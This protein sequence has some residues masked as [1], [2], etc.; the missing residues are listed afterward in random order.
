[1]EPEV[2][3][4][5]EIDVA[6]VESTDFNFEDLEEDKTDKETSESTPEEDEDSLDK[7]DEE[8]TFE[9]ASTEIVPRRVV[10]REKI[11]QSDE[12]DN[13]SLSDLKGSEVSPDYNIQYV[14]EETIPQGGVVRTISGKV[15][16]RFKRIFRSSKEEKAPEPEE[17]STEEETLSVQ[18]L[19]LEP[20][21]I[22]DSKDNVDYDDTEARRALPVVRVT[23]DVGDMEPEVVISD[24]IDVA[25]VESTDFNFED[26][27]E[28][29]TDKETSESTPEEDKDSLDKHDE[30][31]TFETASTEIVPR[32]VVYRE[33]IV[34]SDEHD[35]N[36][37][38]DLK[39]SEV[40]P[41][42]NIQYVE[43][44]TIPQGGFVRTISGKVAGRFKRIFRSS[45][46][47]KAPEPEEIS[48]EK[49]TL[50]VQPL[51]LEPV[52]IAD[53]KDNVDDDDTEAR[54]ALPVVRVTVDVGDMEPE[55]VISD[56]I[57]VAVVESTDFYFEDLEEDEPD[58][59]T[60][61]SIPEEDKDSLDNYDEEATF[62]TA[63]TGIVPRRVVYREKIVQSDEHDNN[64]LSDLKGSE[65]SPDYNIQYV[66]EETIPQG[67]VVRT[68]SG[69]VTGRFKRIFRSSKEEKAPEPEEI[70]TEEET[71]SVQPLSLEPVSITDS[72]DNV[73]YDDTEA[74]RALPVVRVTV[75]VGDMEPEVVIS[76][77]I[78]VAVVESTDFN[79]ED[80]EEDE[81]DKET[82]ESTPEEDEDSLDKHDE[83]ATF[84]TA[85]TEIV[86][87]RVVYREKIVQP[88]EHDN[89]SLSDLKCSEVS[90]DY[91][92]QYVE[93][94][95]IPQGGFVRTISGKVTG[96]FNRIF[97]RSKEEKAP[98]PEEILTEEETLSVQPLSL[99]PVSIADS[100][101]NVDYDDTEARRALPVVRVTVDVGDMEPE[102]VISDEID[103]ALVESTDF[104]FED[105][106]EDETDKETS[107]STFEEDEDSLDKHDEEAFF[108]TASTEIV[109]KRVVYRE[110]IVQSD[111]HDN[112]SLSDLKGSEVSPDYNIQYVEE[113]TI[114][115][116][117]FVRTISGK[118]TG[119]FKRIFRSS[120]EGKAPEPKEILTEE[121]TLSVQPLRLEPVSIADSKDNVDDDDTEA[122][123][124]LPVVRVTVDVGDMEPEVVISDEI[125]V[126]VVESTDFNF[127]DLEEDET[128]KETSESTP[129]EDED[130]LDKHDEEAFFETASTEIVP[131]RVV[132]REKIVQSDEYDNNSLSDLKGSEVS[133]DY[134]IQYVEEETIPQGGVV[135]TISGKVTG[136]FKR[137]F[138][139]SKEE[140][141]PEPEEISTEEETLS[142]QPLSLEPVSI[143]DSKDN[144]DDDDTE[145]R[146]ALP[147]VRVTIDVGDMEPEVVISDEIDVAVVESTDFNFE[148]LEEDE[149]DKETSDSTPEDDKDSLDKHDEEA[150]FETASTEIVPR[151]V[152]YREKIV[153]SDEHDNNSLSD[154]KGSEVS[155]DYNIQYVE[156]E[157]IPQGGVVRTISGKVTGRFK[158]IFRS[159]KE[160]KEPEPEEISTEE[161]TL[162]VQPLSLEPVSIADSKDNVDDDDTE[163]RRALP[164]VRVTID[165]GDME[166]EVVISDEIDVAVV[167]STDFNFEDLE[168]DETD[169]ETSESTPEEDEDSLNNEQVIV[170]SFPTD[171]GLEAKSSD[172]PL[173]FDLESSEIKEDPIVLF[174]APDSFDLKTWS[175]DVDVKEEPIIESLVPIEFLGK[176]QLCEM[177]LFGEP[178]CVYKIPVDDVRTDCHHAFKND[179]SCISGLAAEVPF[180][181]NK[182]ADE[183]NLEHRIKA[184]VVPDLQEKKSRLVIEQFVET[185]LNRIIRNVFVYE[186]SR[187]HQKDQ[188]P[189]D[190][191]Q[192]EVLI[193]TMEGQEPKDM[194]VEEYLAMMREDQETKD[195]TVEDYLAMMKKVREPNDITVEEYLSMMKEDQEP[196]DMTVE[197]YLSMMKEDREPNDMTVEEYLSM[198]KEDQG[199]KDMTVEEYLSVMREDQETKDQTVEEYLAM[200]KKVREPNDITVEEY[201]SMMKE[202]RE[203]NDIT[204]EEYLSMMKEDQEPKDM[205][206]EEYLLRMKE[207]QEPKDM[208]VEKYLSMI[209]E[210]QEP[211]DITVEEYLLMMKEDQEP[212]DMTVEEYLSMMKED[213]GPK[214]MTVEE[215]LS[216]IKEDE[217]QKD[218]TVEKYLSMIKEDEA[219]KDITVEEYL[220]M[221]KKYQEPKDMTVEE[222]LSMMKE[223]QEPKDMTVEKYLSMIKEDE[224]QK[225]ITVEEYLSMMKK[226]QEPKDITV[227]EY[228]SMMKEDQEPKDMT[229]EKYLSMM[230]EDQ[231]TKDQTVEEYLAMMKKVREPKDV[232]VEEYL[233]ILNKDKEPK[234]K[235]VEEYL[236]MMKEDEELK[237]MPIEE[238]L[239]MIEMRRKIKDNEILSQMKTRKL[240]LFTSTFEFT[241]KTPSRLNPFKFFSVCYIHDRPVDPECKSMQKGEKSQIDIEILGRYVAVEERTVTLEFETMAS[242]QAFV[243]TDKD[244]LVNGIHVQ[245]AG[246][247]YVL[248]VT[249]LES[250]IS[251]YDDTVPEF[252]QIALE[253]LV[254]EI[255]IFEE[256]FPS[257]KDTAIE[258][259]VHRS[260][261][262]EDMIQDNWMNDKK[263]LDLD[264]CLAD[265]VYFSAKT[266]PTRHCTEVLLFKRSLR[267][268]PW[269]L[270]LRF[271]ESPAAV[272]SFEPK[273]ENRMDA[274]EI[275]IKSN[276]ETAMLSLPCQLRLVQ[277]KTVSVIYQT[278]TSKYSLESSRSMPAFYQEVDIKVKRQVHGRVSERARAE[279]DRKVSRP[280]KDK[281]Q[282]EAKALK[283]P[284]VFKKTDGGDD[285]IQ[286][287]KDFGV[288][289]RRKLLEEKWQ[290]SLRENDSLKSQEFRGIE[291]K[292]S[293]IIDVGD[294]TKSSAIEKLPLGVEE[295]K[296]NAK[297]SA[298]LF[299]KGRQV[300]G[301][302]ETEDSVLDTTNDSEVGKG[303]KTPFRR[304]RSRQ[305]RDVPRVI[306]KRQKL[307]A[308][309]FG[310]Q[311]DSEISGTETFTE[312]EDGSAFAITAS[313]SVS[314]RASFRSHLRENGF[315]VED[316]S[317]F[318][319]AGSPLPHSKES[320]LSEAETIPES[321]DGSLF[322]LTGSV[323][324]QVSESELSSSDTVVESEDG[325]TFAV[326]GNRSRLISEG[327]S[328]AIIGSPIPI[329]LEDDTLFARD[330]HQN[331][332]AYAITGRK[333]R[334]SESTDEDLAA[335]E[336]RSREL[337]KKTG[338]KN[339]SK[340]AT[341]V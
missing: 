260:K 112:N 47:E 154:L 303:K 34:Q 185:V 220:S 121:E 315:A 136:R 79:F 273:A 293:E 59:E 307:S 332:S 145:A 82:S 184:N 21:S 25:V 239:K 235:T 298:Y 7:H 335:R 106:E 122:R 149:T 147:V 164:V 271:F 86:P 304:S 77:E 322:A 177:R 167:E 243:S 285:R 182:D 49:E 53:S 319:V 119:R 17:I 311:E 37:L 208:T 62:E 216:M 295:L 66:E 301:E 186:I 234:D 45:K 78:D 124:A 207:D 8:A 84:E 110:K 55:V 257:Y 284:P 74:R 288:M 274:S 202:D 201:L 141:E 68:I 227:E 305:S 176:S 195:Q 42:Y 150:S 196:K 61:D 340:L 252:D 133:P 163:A 279:G 261:Q 262:E 204:V 15:T 108:E 56:E 325:C 240:E 28:D 192:V 289:S 226:Y 30:E 130:S 39:G 215:Y 18:P 102:V 85:S 248:P 222:Y 24:E 11:V 29:E 156:E 337:V 83:E 341:F 217:E 329:V 299:S 54:R 219:Q 137:I 203:P 40:S 314:P 233:A 292:T 89:D 171:H 291:I 138:R 32:R 127:E 256:N 134:N 52:S 3:I 232:T 93:E 241:R 16:G 94:E 107:E 115:Q 245:E 225:D 44:E 140:K 64:S 296:G 323:K 237:D 160:E 172:T 230:R 169:K 131:R 168:E 206:V 129:E 157:T 276:Y 251:K 36:S 270:T 328:F 317:T 67:G 65:V 116:G 189:K 165:V 231:D 333:S 278:V 81:T 2:V 255:V 221:M 286:I 158:R 223:D 170:Y 70:S 174:T 97:R 22:T 180:K 1:M 146:R 155:P 324:G 190:A 310:H 152:V 209:K 14:E 35:N 46:E 132:Y 263:E 259:S 320:D 269:V 287:K 212:K 181:L 114:P 6:V 73:D 331:G 148:R 253:N 200:M 99:E 95:T 72:K 294:A 31:A 338:D 313:P 91:N 173:K 71:L 254:P 151:R 142:V 316:G 159:S 210:G 87:R 266:H 267:T 19:S 143:A 179:E 244:I 57:D 228:L 242:L 229:V 246:M 283:I 96:R 308:T 27:E 318:A 50:S 326:T 211:K 213:Q 113:E 125:D 41:D 193:I 10:Y 224:E 144:V 23:V 334:S 111:E 101:D 290:K 339:K 118:V 60:S 69:K 327:S 199:P 277:D 38:S 187:I 90:P 250:H 12:H 300:Y 205:T 75:D 218:I 175:L 76:D 123:R 306:M 43:E 139:S 92:I 51:S 105:L 88:D 281:R 188:K 13:N 275:D 258:N 33:K 249:E 20:V 178:S 194:T 5:D 80:L 236:E 280:E 336:P 330:R 153:Q 109:P 48:T 197:E 264:N 309:Q 161:E 238:Y 162:S 128:D 183:E 265:K 272:S 120:K 198:M 103:V 302:A 191:T 104:K 214:D 98:E 126:A 117:G 166:P 26:L 321:E 312:S 9:T 297:V 268:L 282:T 63:S 135:R 100:K 247:E 58:K 4:S